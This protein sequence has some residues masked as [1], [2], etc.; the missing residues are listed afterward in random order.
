M[1]IIPLMATDNLL[2]PEGIMTFMAPPRRHPHRRRRAAPAAPASCSPGRF[3]RH[4]PVVA[5]VE[6]PDEIGMDD[7][8]IDFGGV[9][10]GVPVEWSAESWRT[11]D[12]PPPQAKWSRCG[13]AETSVPE[14]DQDSSPVYPDI[15]KPASGDCDP[16]AIIDPQGNV[17]N[18]RVLRSIPCSTSRPS[19]RSSSGIRAH[20]AERGSRSHRMTVTV[21]FS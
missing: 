9:A 6:I 7:L 14:Q 8:G 13:W 19:T 4:A 17:T 16:G 15:A 5:P 2:T 11:P 20:A 3:S 1:V 18:V 21:N 12:A 10:G